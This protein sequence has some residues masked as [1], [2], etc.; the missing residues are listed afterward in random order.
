MSICTLCPR[1][2]GVDRDVSRGFCG[3]RRNPNVARAALHFWEEPFISGMRG[4][5]TIFFCGCNL[6]CAFCQNRAINHTLI[7]PELD[8]RALAGIMLSLQAQGAH[9]VNLVSPAPFVPILCEAIPFARDMGLVI[10]V[11]YNTNAYEKAETLRSLSGLVDVYLPDLKYVSSQIA[12]KYSGAADYFAF[13]SRAI[14]EM[15]VQCGALELDAEGVATRGVAIRHLVLPGS[16]DET[17][18]VIDCIAERFSPDIAF[19]LMGQYVPNGRTLPAP[20]GRRL[21]NR[22]YDRAVTYALQK[23]LINVLIQ[24]LSSASLDFTPEFDGELSPFVP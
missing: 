24:K 9:N 22:E 16:V 4:S 8:A 15:Y 6:D 23:G 7:G 12:L 3:A 20:L 19:S 10:P 2:C 14:D 5:G 17:R 18:R 21:L 13:A 11:V 1:A